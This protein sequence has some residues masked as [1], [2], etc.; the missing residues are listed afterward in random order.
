M[1]ENIVENKVKIFISSRCDNGRY[2]IMRKGLKELLVN[3]GLVSVYIFEDAASSSFCVEDSYMR[4]L[5]SSDLCVFIINNDEDITEGVVKEYT[6][7]KTLG[8]R[9]MYFFCDENSKVKTPMQKEIEE[10]GLQRYKVVHEFS[11]LIHEVYRGIIQDITNMYKNKNDIS[12]NIRIEQVKEKSE[13]IVYKIKKINRNGLQITTK[14][15]LK[16]IISTSDNIEEKKLN[17]FDLLCS[18]FLNVVLRRKKID[19]EKFETLKTMILEMHEENLKKLINNRLEAVKLYYNGQIGECIEKLKEILGHKYEGIPEWMINDVAIDLRNLQNIHDEINNKVRFE[20]DGQK[21]INNSEETV[22]YPLIDR[23]DENRKKDILKGIIN[24]QLDSPYSRRIENI[25]YIFEYITLC[26]YIALTNGSITHLRL[27]LNRIAETLLTFNFRYTNHDLYV[28]TIK[29][30]ILTQQDKEIG[31]LLRTYKSNID[32]I[33]SEDISKI[34]NDIQNTE[35]KY[36]KIISESILLKYFNFY[37]SDQQYKEIFEK[38]CDNINLWLDDDNRTIHYDYYYFDMLKNN[39]VRGDNK[40]ICEIIIKT[41]NNKL[42]RFYDNALEILKRIDY[43]A[44]S[45]EEQEVVMQYLMNFIKEKDS[46]NNLKNLQ[47]AIIYFRKETT[48]PNKNKLDVLIENNMSEEFVNIYKLETEEKNIN[49]KKMYIKECIRRI[50]Q[51]NM[52]QGKNGV[53]TSGAANDYITIRNIIKIDN[54][55]ME[56]KE[57]NKLLETLVETLISERQTIS[58]KNSAIQLM[59]YLKKKFYNKRIWKKYSQKIVEDSDIFISGKEDI[60]FD[61]ESILLMKINMKLLC[62]IFDVKIK[63]E[64]LDL[65]VSI[66]QLEDFEKIEALKSIYYF[67]EDIDYRRIDNKLIESILQCVSI[68][69]NESDIDIRFW[70]TKNL[71]QLTY[72]E[73]QPRAFKQLIYIM[74]FGSSELKIAIISRAKEIACDGK[75][76]FIEFIINKGKADNNFLVKKVTLDYEKGENSVENKK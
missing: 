21:Q 39:L 36:Y 45:N 73:Y 32:V 18:E 51:Q 50:H 47:N 69:S 44:V 41:F 2:T 16:G 13:T 68:M 22:Y 7:A 75:N 9:A 40:T 76:E 15:L 53:Y 43:S 10:Q 35:I 52:E 37:F 38:T 64:D 29:F 58:A 3:T 66:M 62:T 74:N 61:N 11:D 20:N 59:I 67:L 57:L 25:N 55:M 5:E 24:Y 56:T 23:I 34:Y 63:N 33:N 4:E 70:A 8:K 19:N 54:I 30:L 46:R 12:Q 48:V 6:K 26:F 27:T 60:F 1:L 71:I 65:I 31:K 17:E 28:Q 49:H 14:E 72:S 42:K